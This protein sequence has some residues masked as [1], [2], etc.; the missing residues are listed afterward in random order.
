MTQHRKKRIRKKSTTRLGP[1]GYR[2]DK[3]GC[4]DTWDIYD[5]CDNG[6][7][8]SIPFWDCGPAWMEL[9]ETTARL[10]AASPDLAQALDELVGA[11]PNGDADL[12][13]NAVERASAIIARA[14]GR[15]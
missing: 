3:D 2:P 7:I 12:Y 11:W 15:E 5:L 9:S 4:D 10:F 1:F 8:A 13:H 6:V 14:M